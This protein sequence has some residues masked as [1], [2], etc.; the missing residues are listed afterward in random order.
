[1]NSRLEQFINDHRDEFDSEEPGKKIWDNI[2]KQIDPEKK[3]QAPVVSINW[4]TWSVAAVI[5]VL[6]GG[7]IVLTINR[8]STV[9]NPGIATVKPATDNKLPKVQHAAIDTHSSQLAQSNV[10]PKQEIKKNEPAADDQLADMNEEMYHFA[11]LVEIRHKELGKIKKDEPLLYRQFA[12]DVN[13]LDSVFHSLE[14]QLPENPNRE[15]LLEAM[16]QNLQLQMDLLNHQLTI[17]K[18]INHSKKSAYEK[19]FKST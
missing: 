19:A 1:M 14:K 12:G 17:I 2:Q 10:Q 4:R 6:L 15:Q 3:Q 9:V 5:A 8:K 11:K 13:K 7:G 18:Q 16:I